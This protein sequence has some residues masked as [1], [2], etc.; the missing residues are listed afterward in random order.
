MWISRLRSGGSSAFASCSVNQHRVV[1]AS[2]KGKE[3]AHINAFSTTSKRIQLPRRVLD[4]PRG[5]RNTS[6]ETPAEL[7]VSYPVISYGTTIV[8]LTLG[9][10]AGITLPMAIWSRNRMKR[11]KQIVKPEMRRLNDK[12]AVEVAK[13]SRQKG[14]S[15]DEYRKALK[16]RVSQSSIHCS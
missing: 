10:R 11:I 16:L 15:Y 2:V 3:T 6:W 13:E 8:L 5:R 12:L 7:L 4:S 1:I 14:L 9:F